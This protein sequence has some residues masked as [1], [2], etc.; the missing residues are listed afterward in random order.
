MDIPGRLTALRAR[1][2]AAGVCLYLVPTSDFH[3]SE[4]VGEYFKCREYLSGFTGSAGT[5]LV[6]ENQ[7]WLGT[8]GRY[9]LQAQ[10]QL[11]GSG[12]TLMRMGEEG[13]PTL[14]EKL[15]ELCGPGAVLGFDGRTLSA[16][17]VNSL[18]RKLPGL[19]LR[20]DLDLAGEVWPG[21]PALSRQPVWELPAQTAGRG[22]AAPAHLP[23]RDR[24]A[25]QP[26][27]G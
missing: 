2:A 4:Y 24:L 13:V 17:F 6:G 9:F 3:G 25:L 26:A 18:R 11:E 27:G 1:M 21:R 15:A 12:I 7:A 16:R 20:P 19:A 14:P 10:R 23:G 8:D 5:L 22:R